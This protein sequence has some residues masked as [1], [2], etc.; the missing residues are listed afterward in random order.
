[1]EEKELVN[2]LNYIVKLA[3]KGSINKIKDFTKS[4]IIQIKISD[5]DTTDEYVDQLLKELK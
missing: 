4:L 5:K 3:E 1:M 2:C